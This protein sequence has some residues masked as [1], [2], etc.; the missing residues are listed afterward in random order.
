MFSYKNNLKSFFLLWERKKCQQLELISKQ[1]EKERQRFKKEIEEL[2]IKLTKI[3]DEN[4]F[5]KTSMAQSASQFQIIQEELLEKASK[6]N[7]LEQE[8]SY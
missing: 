5:L 6:T 7:S 8:V 1:F 3:D 2:C 4:S